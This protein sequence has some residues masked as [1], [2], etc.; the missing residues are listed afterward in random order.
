MFAADCPVIV[1]PFSEQNGAWNW[2]GPLQRGDDT[3][4]PGAR[5][6]SGERLRTAEHRERGDAVTFPAVKK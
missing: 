3:S 2:R 4:L 5:T 6:L 1:R